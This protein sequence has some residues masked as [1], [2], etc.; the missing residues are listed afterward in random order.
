VKWPNITEK[1]EGPADGKEHDG[2]SGK[3]EKY[4]SAEP[5]Q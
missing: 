3:F 5:G 2:E 1:K 4:F